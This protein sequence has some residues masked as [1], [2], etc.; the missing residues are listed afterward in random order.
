M[1]FAVQ[2]QLNA[3]LQDINATTAGWAE[4]LEGSY[5]PH[6]IRSYTLIHYVRS[7]KGVLN[8][9]GKTYQV[10]GGQAFIMRPG[11]MATY[12]ADDQNPWVYNWASFTGRLTADFGALPPVFDLPE[13]A[14][15]VL[16]DL[17]NV[18]SPDGKHPGD[19]VYRLSCDL[20]L[21]YGKYLKHEEK[22]VDY[23]Q[24]ILNHIQRCY[25]EK[26]SVEDFADQFGIDRRYMSRQFKKKLGH[27]IQEHILKTRM[28]QA[29]RY[30][31]MGCS[32]KQTAGL[33]GYSAVS[34]FSKLFK[35]TY[36]IT[37]KYWRNG[38]QEETAQRL[39]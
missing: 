21:F 14:L 11:E 25:M 5:H 39:T 35:R 20:L 15:P 23:I 6:K 24:Q 17:H 10:N 3:H 38:V 19:L 30:L 12:A 33:C 28:A 26:L 18:I 36:G 22:Q 31:E 29:E 27:T 1:E 32:V 7:G 34:T 9:G 2:V 13:D 8:I 4:N 37:P 16:K